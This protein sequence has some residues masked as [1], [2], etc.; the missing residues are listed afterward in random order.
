MIDP[1]HFNLACGHPARASNRV[2]RR[3]AADHIG[4]VCGPCTAAQPAGKGARSASGVVWSP[5]AD[6]GELAARLQPTA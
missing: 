1:V 2:A 4:M 5:P 6:P 3:I